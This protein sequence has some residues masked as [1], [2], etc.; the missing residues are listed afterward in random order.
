MEPWA[1]I[2]AWLNANEGVVALL[3]PLAGGIIAVARS[4]FLAGRNR[5][6]PTYGKP[7]PFADFST[8]LRGWIEAVFKVSRRSSSSP[9]V[10]GYLGFAFDYLPLFVAQRLGFL[11]S[12]AR[13]RPV[14]LRLFSDFH[15]LRSAIDNREIAFVALSS[16]PA[17]RL[18]CAGANISAIETLSAH[19]QCI[20][21]P[22]PEVSVLRDLK[23]AQIATVEFSSS[24]FGA[25]C[26]LDASGIEVGP[27]RFMFVDED[28]GRELIRQREVSAWAIW[29]LH[30]DYEVELTGAREVVGSE[31]PIYSILVTVGELSDKTLFVARSVRDA[32][33]T[34]K[35]WIIDNEAQA[36]RFAQREF[37][38]PRRVVLAAW[39][40]F[41][42]GATLNEDTVNDLKHNGSAMVR[43]GWFGAEDATKLE[44]FVRLI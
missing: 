4:L 38:V 7:R 31:V 6:A 23:G 12:M 5:H 17:T 27:D 8:W 1:S 22:W 43:H 21:T 40:R 16:V 34:A 19:A 13:N 11:K 26:S 44:T 15:A 30:S 37:G 10:I 39:R 33:R 36:I 35:S 3:V 2:I 14:E 28:K 32:M 24:H 29:P 42:F 18:R 41:A 20:V 25:L 9:I